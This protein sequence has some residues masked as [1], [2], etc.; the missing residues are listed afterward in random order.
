MMCDHNVPWW[1]DVSFGR[2]HAELILKPSYKTGQSANV[3]YDLRR[4]SLNRVQ[5]HE[6]NTPLWDRGWWNKS[7]A[8]LVALPNTYNGRDT[9]SDVY[10]LLYDVVIEYRSMYE[11]NVNT[12]IFDIKLEDTY[13]LPG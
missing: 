5:S 6:F 9:F 12:T 10:I 4:G 13:V 3:H 7:C 1:I 11:M 2:L 8:R